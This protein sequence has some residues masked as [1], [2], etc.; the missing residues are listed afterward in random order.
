MLCSSMRSTTF[1]LA[2]AS[3]V[4]GC[5]HKPAT[6]Q[7]EAADE[8]IAI[9]AAER[10][11]QGARLVAID[12]RGDRQFDLLEVPDSISRD[13]HPALS[14][15]GK[16]V[17]FA[18][19][20]GRAIDETS[21]WIAPLTRSA[22]PRRLT[23]DASI[24]SHPV[25]LP[26]SSAIVFASTRDGGDFDLVSLA[27]ANGE[28]VGAPVAL[29][30]NAGH[31]VTP[32]VARDGTIYYAAVTPLEGGRIESRIAARAKDGNV[33]HVTAG[34]ADTSPALSPDERTLVFARPVQ[35]KTGVDAELWAMPRNGAPTTATVLVELPLTDESGPVWSP[36]G[37]YVFAT[38]LLRGAEGNAVFSSVIVIDTQTRPLTAR[39]LQDRTGAIARLT[40]AIANT[41]LDAAALAAD[42]EYLP[43][44]ARIMAA[45]RSAPPP[46]EPSS[47]P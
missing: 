45:A 18:S 23:A 41:R 47:P 27:I 8:R 5:G 1:T 35:H 9:V 37:R 34:P 6:E 44:L 14:P 17:V 42:P 13:S 39:L 3:A 32:A 29:T 25:W 7:P 28:A 10:G 12:E 46:G 19:S 30:S 43:E 4:A 36:D 2:L 22:V 16:W 26:D 38:S 15:D 11:P 31:E 24:E 20:R 33:T 40:P 21:L